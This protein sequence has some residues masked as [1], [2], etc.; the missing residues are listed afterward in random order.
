VVAILG[1]ASSPGGN[2]VRILTTIVF[3][4]VLSILSWLAM[5]GIP[6]AA[7]FT[8]FPSQSNSAVE[9]VGSFAREYVPSEIL[10]WSS[11]TLISGLVSR[12]AGNPSVWFMT[13]VAARAAV[14]IARF[15]LRFIYIPF[16]PLAPRRYYVW[17]R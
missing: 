9:F 3:S 6:I 8:F 5:I 14:A 17:R 1:G 7:C 2:E 13:L 10:N 4:L 15:L 11:L 16:V 12:I